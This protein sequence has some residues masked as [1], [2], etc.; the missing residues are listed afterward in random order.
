M[1]DLGDFQTP[2]ALVAA[3]LERLGPVG[4]RWERVLEPTCGE[5]RFVSALLALVPPPREILGVELQPAHV[6][7]ARAAAAAAPAGVRVG[8]T[9]GSLFDLDLS[10][11][12]DWRSDGPLLVVGN[13][14]WVTNA[15][16]GA[17]GS[18]HRPARV[19]RDRTR[20]IDAITGASNFDLAEAVWHKLLRELADQRPTI[21]LLCKT[22]VAFK[23]LAHAAKAGLPVV[24]ASVVQINAREWFGAAVEACLLRLTIGG[25][26]KS[27]SR[28]PVY[29]GLDR[30]SPSSWM[31]LSRGRVVADWAAYEAS[32][33]ADG[34]CPFVW[35]QGLKH[36]AAD[37]VELRPGGG[38]SRSLVNALGEPADIEPERVFALLKATDL[39][40]TT[41][42]EPR[43]FAVVTQTH[44]GDD[45]GRI[46]REA[47]RLWAYLKKHA[48][49]FARRRSSVYRG[50]A[51]FAMFGVGPYTFA[52]YKTAVS[53]L[54]RSPVFHAVGPDAA[55]RPLVFD[56]ACYFASFNSPEPAALAAAVL[57]EPAAVGL[58]RS[59]AAPGA[60][61]PV[62]KSILSRVDVAAVFSRSDRAAIVDRATADVLRIAGRNPVWLEPIERLFEIDVGR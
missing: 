17:L 19:N 55:G 53:G 28:A 56:D 20:G 3:V 34:A 14:P 41:P 44:P 2:P 4:R 10:T 8:L 47:P 35:R 21:A 7:A 26:R 31:G 16:L 58:L 43:R 29:E 48:A 39:S 49:P 13:P 61:R 59:L 45:T 27:A 33:F 5:G 1:K 24:D 46:R 18:P 52:P 9:E 30:R 40:R 25:G 37:V 60:K 22:T 11:A 32:E 51:E 50:R 42:P 12:L 38:R 15:A 62:T 54:H 36:D 57:N 23:V 6:A